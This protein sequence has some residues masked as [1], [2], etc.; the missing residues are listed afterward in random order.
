VTTF[1]AGDPTSVRTEYAVLLPNGK[2]TESIPYDMRKYLQDKDR[3]FTFGKGGMTALAEAV[4]DHYEKV[5]AT[6]DA[7]VIQREVVTTYGD[8]VGVEE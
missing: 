3:R 2:V 7:R 5:G 4:N 1:V 8:W 6:P